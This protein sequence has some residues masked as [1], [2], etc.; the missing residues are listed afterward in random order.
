MDSSENIDSYEIFHRSI[1]WINQAYCFFLSCLPHEAD[2]YPKKINGIHFMD[3]DHVKVYKN[4]LSYSFLIRIFGALEKLCNELDLK[5]KD[6]PRII[7]NAS[8]LTCDIKEDYI[9][10]RKLR[11]VITHGNGLG[12]VIRDK[13]INYTKDHNGDLFIK[14]EELESFV[15]AITSVGKELNHY[16]I[17]NRLKSG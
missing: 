2:E 5:D 7:Q 17:K 12:E 14:I 10:V 3:S 8:N 4:E 9:H 13:Y 6:I 15:K 1:S 16:A 11:H